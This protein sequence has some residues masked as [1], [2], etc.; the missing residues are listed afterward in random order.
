[1]MI[2]LY[3]KHRKA[4]HAFFFHAV[5]HNLWKLFFVW[6]FLVDEICSTAAK[7][8]I[9]SILIPTNWK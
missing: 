6:G 9:D 7:N 3:I 2:L 4:L 1:M 8:W 5:I